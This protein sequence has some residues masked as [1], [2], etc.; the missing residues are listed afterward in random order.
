M[1][2]SGQFLSLFDMP[3]INNITATL[4]TLIFFHFQLEYIFQYRSV[5][6]CVF[7]FVCFKKEKPSARR[8]FLLSVQQNLQFAWVS[9]LARSDKKKKQKN[10]FVFACVCF[11]CQSDISHWLNSFILLH[12][13]SIDT[14]DFVSLWWIFFGCVR[15]FFSNSFAFYFRYFL[16]WTAK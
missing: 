1:N 3:S 15:V 9:Q 11:L 5:C 12:S 6:V 10:R 4:L 16:I 14:P 2:R 13:L 7:H 8:I